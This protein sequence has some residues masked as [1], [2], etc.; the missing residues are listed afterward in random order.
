MIS[1][2]NI[3]L[4][5]VSNLWFIHSSNAQTTAAPAEQAAVAYAL[6]SNISLVSDYRFRGVSQTYR[7]PAI[8]GRF[9]YT[10]ASGL[11]VGIWN[12]SVSSNSYNNGA[13]LEIDLYGGYRFAITRD[14]TGDVGALRYFSPRAR[15]NSASGVPTNGKYNTT[16][17]YFALTQ[18]N[19]NG[20]L[21]YAVSD[22]FGLNEATTGFAYFNALPDR[23]NSSGTTYLDLNYGVDMGNQVM[24][25][26]HAGHISVRRYTELSHTDSKL[27]VGKELAGVMF[28]VALV[29]TN[30]DSR[31]YQIADTAGMN[32]KPVAKTAFVI[33]ATKS[34]LTIL[35][36]PGWLSTSP[37]WCYASACFT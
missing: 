17:I 30:A 3:I 31:F 23:G 6:M 33:Y 5:A 25:G 15:L 18:G 29:G 8:Q 28:N 27:S 1:K 16:E 12:S 13:S 11:Y 35:R 32:A 20:K 9:D 34:F 37:D 24:L 2:K 22:Y 7:Q 21:S 26:L 10:H 36:P 19:F 4:F 14:M